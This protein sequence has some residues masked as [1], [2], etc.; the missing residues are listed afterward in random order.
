MNEITT[1]LM[2]GQTRAALQ[3]KLR[4]PM[5]PLRSYWQHLQLLT[6]QNPFWFSSC[7]VLAFVVIGEEVYRRHAREL[8]LRFTKAKDA[9]LLTKEV[10]YHTLSVAKIHPFDRVVRWS[11][12]MSGDGAL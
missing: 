7:N 10:Q 1:L 5:E 3:A 2:A 11:P 12:C 8:F 6:R 9:G 4:Q